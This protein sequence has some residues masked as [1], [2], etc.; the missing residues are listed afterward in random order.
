MKMKFKL[1]ALDMDG[2]VNSTQLTRN[3]INSKYEMNKLN[4]PNLSEL[5]LRDLT[6]Q[7]FNEFFDYKTEL[8][9]PQ[10][11]EKITTICEKTNCY[12][13]WTSSW[14][15]VPKYNDMEKTKEMFNRNNLPGDRLIGY[16]PNHEYFWGNSIRSD[17]IRN[18][19]E[20]NIYGIVEKCAVIDDSSYAGLNLPDNAKFFKTDSE[21]GITDS[22]VKNICKYL[23]S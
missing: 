15:L 1:L 22:H 20:N 23:N 6:E 11:A 18:W 14:R 4:F 3:W 21:I 13:L 19:L 2:V 16:T 12:I 10:L 9:F 8:I 17:E 7:N 5:Q